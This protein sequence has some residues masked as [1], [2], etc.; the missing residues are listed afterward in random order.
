MKNFKGGN[1]DSR[2]GGKR[3]GGKP[4]FGGGRPSFGGRGGGD[5]PRFGGG[6]REM[7]EATCADCGRRTE[8]PFRPTGDKP[9]YCRDCFKKPEH[10][11]G[12]GGDRRD[13]GHGAPRAPRP[14]QSDSRPSQPLPP[15]DVR[16]PRID[17]I[18]RQLDAMSTK[19]DQLIQANKQ[20]D[21]S[22]AVSA[23]TSPKPAVSKTTA[24]KTTAPKSKVAKAPKKKSK[25][26]K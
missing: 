20:S 12:G 24:P 3:F 19:L 16:D 21:L 9:V 6:D 26:K 8:V 22:K 14:F 1:G 2:G 5:R 4:S 11:P 18:K 25:G 7:F 17:D 23:A 15:R 10:A 13:F